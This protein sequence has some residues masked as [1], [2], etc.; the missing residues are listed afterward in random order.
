MQ[1][2]CPACQSESG[3]FCKP[4]I[5]YLR[6]FGAI[7]LAYSGY[8]LC[9]RPLT[10]GRQPVALDILS[11]FAG[12]IT[13]GAAATPSFPVLVWSG[14]KG[15]DKTRQRALFQPFILVIQIV[16]LTFISLAHR[17]ASA[18]A[19][20]AASDLLYIPASILGTNLGLIFF[21]GMSDFQFA[22][23]VNIL[24]IVSGIAFVV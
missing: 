5:P 14:L 17:S 19:G 24:L 22:C 13:G 8:V 11:G 16:A 9:R 6:A 3:S 20:F 12:G 7:L 15:W 21:Q 10:L 1:A 2:D 23:V 4:T 18:H